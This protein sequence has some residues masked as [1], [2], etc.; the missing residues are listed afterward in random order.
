MDGGFGCRRFADAELYRNDKQP[1]FN[2]ARSVIK[3][4]AY[5]TQES[6]LDSVNA[7]SANRRISYGVSETP[8]YPRHDNSAGAPRWMERSAALLLCDVFPEQPY[9]RDS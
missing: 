9:T 6:A 5:T 3:R 4:K 8:E 7:G 1:N 2:V